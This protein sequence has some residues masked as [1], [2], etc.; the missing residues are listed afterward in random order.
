MPEPVSIL[1]SPGRYDVTRETSCFVADL[2]RY[3]PK[4]RGRPV[5]IS[6]IMRWI[7]HGV[8]GPDGRLVR[9]EAVRMGGWVTSLEA[10]SRFTAALTPAIT[11][12]AQST[13]P[14]TPGQRERA[15]LRAREELVRRGVLPSP[16]AEPSPGHSVT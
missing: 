1:P 8:K 6:T 7:N 3:L 16:A 5:H 10:V 11:P 12:H 9:L 13:L 2:P 4:R 15:A 14:R